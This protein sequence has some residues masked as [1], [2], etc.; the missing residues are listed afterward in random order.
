MSKP[1]MEK[2]QIKMA[3]VSYQFKSLLDSFICL[4]DLKDSLWKKYFK[5]M[6]EREINRTIKR[7]IYDILRLSSLSFIV[8]H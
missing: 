1:G 3:D 7:M 8:R 5:S 2:Y 4:V 6:T